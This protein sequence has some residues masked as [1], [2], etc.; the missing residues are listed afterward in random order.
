MDG[1]SSCQGHCGSITVIA[2]VQQD[3]L[4]PGAH[5]G[6]NRTE[7]GLGSTRHHGD[8]GLRIAAYPAMAGELA[9]NGLPQ[10][11]QSGHWGVLVVAF[12]GMV[13]KGGAQGLWRLEIRETLGQVQG[14]LLVGES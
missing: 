11:R 7:N 13:G 14:V 8:L 6:G 9:G 3:D 2:G 10:R 1:N 5:A 12:Q 4:V